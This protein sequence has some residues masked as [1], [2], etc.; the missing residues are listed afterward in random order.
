MLG[1][2][3]ELRSSHVESR[4]RRQR[5]CCAAIPRACANLLY[6]TY[7]PCMPC[8]CELDLERRWVRARAWGAVTY[9]EVMATR[10]KFTSDPEFTPYFCQL[11][12]GRDV[13]RLALTASQVGELARATL[14]GPGSRRAFV[15]P[16]RE[17]YGVVR[18][19]KIYRE[20]NAGREKIDLFRSIE[21]AEAWLAG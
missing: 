19:F 11:Y 1:C 5:I 10:R 3:K 4:I 6:L 2:H 7:D 13:T 8:D 14:F 9:D 20:I 15:A 17:T 18:L 12:D 16:T 21:E